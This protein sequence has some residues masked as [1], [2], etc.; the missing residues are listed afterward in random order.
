MIKYIYKGV[1]IS[2]EDLERAINKN[3]TEECKRYMR[4]E[5]SAFLCRFLSHKIS[6]GLQI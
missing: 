2:E 4:R 1:R 6:N 5:I 3:S